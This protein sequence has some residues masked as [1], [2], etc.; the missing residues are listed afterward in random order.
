MNPSCL[1]NCVCIT[2]DL[3]ANVVAACIDLELDST[4]R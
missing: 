3:E 1:I 2:V 4:K